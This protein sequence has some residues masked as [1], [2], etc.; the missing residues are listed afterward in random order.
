[1]DCAYMTLFIIIT[2]RGGNALRLQES[3]HE[4]KTMQ[5]CYLIVR[6]R[7][8]SSLLLTVFVVTSPAFDFRR[9]EKTEKRKNASL[10]AA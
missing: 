9:S 3:T 8:W 5:L 4:L 7:W 10:T 6:T 1:M 2:L